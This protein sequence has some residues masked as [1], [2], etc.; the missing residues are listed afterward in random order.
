MS[1]LGSHGAT[2]EKIDDGAL[3]FSKAYELNAG[4]DDAIRFRLCI[5]HLTRDRHFDGG[6]ELKAHRYATT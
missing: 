3:R 4:S 6:T 1:W 2:F 5:S